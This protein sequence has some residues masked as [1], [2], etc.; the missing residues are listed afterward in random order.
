MDI[1]VIA[2]NGRRNLFSALVAEVK[3]GQTRIGSRT[4]GGLRIVLPRDD[5]DSVAWDRSY[6]EIALEVSCQHITFA[7][8]LGQTICKNEIN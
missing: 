5:G 1:R 6:Y 4:D 7:E 3:L 2:Y 8:I